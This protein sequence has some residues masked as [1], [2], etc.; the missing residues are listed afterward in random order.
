MPQ[1]ARTIAIVGPDGSGKTTQAKLLTER[2]QAAGYDA[3][4]VHALYYLSDN[5]PCADRLRRH[6]G[7]RKTRTQ[8]TEHGLLY[9]VRRVLFGL[10]GFWFALLT[11][12]MVS[13]QVRNRRQVVVF[14]RYYHQFFYDVYGS[15]SIPLSR[16]LPHPW[17][18]IYLDADL[19]TVQIR[20]DTVDQ[21]VDRQYYATVIDLYDECATPE[22]LSFRA[23][24]P[25]ETL[26]EQIF[27]AIW[28]RS[29]PDHLTTAAIR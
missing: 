4:Y 16:L 6:L 29:G 23:E 1:L 19:T 7:P 20:M 14:D 11:I 18:M 21:A 8:E 27:Q 28:D 2:L 12:G 17:Q 26:H 13:L 24:L 15:A 5:I 3:Q 10:V 22:W 9:F 25:I